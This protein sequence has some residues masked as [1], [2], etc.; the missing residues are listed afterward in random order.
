MFEMAAK[1]D[2]KIIFKGKIDDFDPSTSIDYWQSKST[3]EKFKETCSLIDQA[4][5]LKGKSISDVSGLLRTTA[6]LKRQ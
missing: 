2:W 5:R 6:V 3:A 4:L 1:K